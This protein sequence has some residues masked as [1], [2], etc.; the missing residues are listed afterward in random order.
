M[1]EERAADVKCIC[2]TIL[3]V[4]RSYHLSIHLYKEK[5]HTNVDLGHYSVHPLQFPTAQISLRRSLITPITVLCLSYAE[6]TSD[7]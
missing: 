7:F 4:E 3:A 2:C 6:M 1:V 5:M